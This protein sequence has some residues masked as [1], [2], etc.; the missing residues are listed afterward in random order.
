MCYFFFS[1]S[2]DDIDDD[3]T[4]FFEDLSKDVADLIGIDKDSAGYIFLQE[5][6]VGTGWPES[7]GDALTQCKV[8]VPVYTSRFMGSNTCGREYYAFRQRL[9]HASRPWERVVPIWWNPPRDSIPSAI[10]DVVD[11]RRLLRLDSQEFGLKVIFRERNQTDSPYQRLLAR[12]V[13]MI[14]TRGEQEP[15]LPPGSRPDLVNGT[16]IFDLT[17]TGTTPGYRPSGSKIVTFL[18]VSGTREEMDA[19]P[20]RTCKDY[21]GANR[22]QWNPFQPSNVRPLAIEASEV[23]GQTPD[24][25]FGNTCTIFP[26]DLNS[27]IKS[28]EDE[29]E[30][31]I[32]L[33]DSWATHIAELAYLLA[34]Y[35]SHQYFNSALIVPFPEDDQETV[36]FEDNLRHNLWQKIRRTMSGEGSLYREDADTLATFKLA[37]AEVLQK[38]VAR[39]IMDAPPPRQGILNKR[40]SMP[41][42]SPPRS[43]R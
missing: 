13:R 18:T 19:I 1:C 39:L 7:A 21:Y 15:L 24:H 6:S 14:V 43:P 23:A 4:G 35:D 12:L 3:L 20:N 32:L 2:G 22:E 9:I 10:E 26:A 27:F 29:R 8:F 36:G 37:M 40:E 17:P 30:M 38:L 16:N 34:D 31:V 42:L 41:V 25:I 28:K 33:V 5:R 11:P